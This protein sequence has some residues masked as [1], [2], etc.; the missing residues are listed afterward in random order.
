MELPVSVAEREDE[1]KAAFTLGYSESI[2]HEFGRLLGKQMEA[3]TGKAVEFGKPDL[4]II[5]NPFTEKC[6]A[7]GEPPLRRRQ[8]QETRQRHPAVEVVLFQLPRQRLPKMRRNR[9]DVPRVSGSISFKT[10]SWKLPEAPKASFHA[11]GREDIDARMLG[12]GRPFVVE[13]SK[14]KK[15]SL[16]LESSDRSHQC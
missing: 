11:S 9:F 4:M 12:T 2:K 10:H 15:R 14:P 6:Q 3:K 5:V 1:F 8:I 7:A 13:I 16:D